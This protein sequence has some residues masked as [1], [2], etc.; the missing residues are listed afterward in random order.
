MG[1]QIIYL[2][3]YIDSEWVQGWC[4]ARAGAW[5]AHGRRAAL[6]CPLPRAHRCACL[7][8]SSCRG[9]APRP[10][11]TTS[12]PA[13]LNR[14]L[15]SIKD[16]DERSDGE[17]ARRAQHGQCSLCCG[18][19]PAAAAPA[20]A[21]PSLPTARTTNRI[22]P[23]RPGGP[24]P[25][26]CGGGAEA[27]A[28]ARRHQHAKQGGGRRVGWAPRR[29]WLLPHGSRRGGMQGHCR[30]WNRREAP[31]LA[32]ICSRHLMP[33]HAMCMQY[34][35]RGAHR[36]PFTCLPR[37]RAGGAAGADRERPAPAHPVCR[38][39]GAAG[40][41]GE[42]CCWAGLQARCEMGTC[43]CSAHASSACGRPQDA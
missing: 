29:S 42:A 41:A 23:C 2:E 1:D 21:S 38:G 13:E 11:G 24:D 14:I 18:S 37:R 40:G 22:H 6:P 4:R 12:L 30:C 5:R 33:S 9:I 26:E 39:E 19:A 43:T 17:A 28:R 10:A 7:P 31:A 15:N 35:A 25:G 27:A 34:G 32:A 8:A 20:A 36:S 16:L 3:K